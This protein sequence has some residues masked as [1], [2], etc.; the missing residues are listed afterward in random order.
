MPNLDDTTELLR[1]LGDPTRVR[2]L[3]LLAREELTVAELTQITQVTQSRVSTHLGKLREAGVV[4]DRKAG[5]SSFYSL[6][7]ASMPA[8]ARKVWELVRESTRDP[9]IDEDRTRLSAVQRGKQR[10]E[11]W[12][13][14]VAGSMERHYS[15]GRTW[16][17]TL[18][19]LIGLMR[20]GDVLDIASGDGAIA[21]LVA[22]RARSLTCVDVSEKVIAAAKSRLSR[23][24]NVRFACADMHALPFEDASFDQV[25]LLNCLTCAHT[26]RRVLA[27]VARVLRPGGDLCGV[28]LKTHQHEDVAASYGHIRLG[29]SPS[30]LRSSLEKLGFEVA[31]C[32]VSSREKRPPHFE[33]ITIHA[34]RSA[35]MTRKAA[36]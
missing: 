36:R 23:H 15:P 7:D 27:E 4:R 35:R 9:L 21:E 3:A 14:S 2:L 1:L 17:A 29:F 34:Q 5:A 10:G 30:G 31:S 28:T 13:D 18:R 26:P 22:P 25:M 19:G 8:E 24:H 12:A 16:E 33:I 11:S 32:Q 6:N 20:L